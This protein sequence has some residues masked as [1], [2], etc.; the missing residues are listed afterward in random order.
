MAGKPHQAGERQPDAP[1]ITCKVVGVTVCTACAA[2]LAVLST[3]ATPPASRVHCISLAAGALL[4]GGMGL[5][6]AIG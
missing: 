2:Y 6:R 1:C 3:T 5:A 4:F